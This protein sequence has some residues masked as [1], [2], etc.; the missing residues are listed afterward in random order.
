LRFLTER[1][2]KLFTDELGQSV[3]V[4]RPHGMFF[5]HRQI[6]G[7]ERG[8][9]IVEPVNR[10]AGAADGFL[11]SDCLRRR[12][13]V[14]GHRQVRIETR[15]VARNVRKLPALRRRVE[16]ALGVRKPLARQM[17]HRVGIFEVLEQRV[18][19]V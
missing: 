17:N 16:S 6:V 5:I 7:N 3:G 15:G 9:R 10:Q 13:D 11:H 12:Q 14:I 8:R 18:N 2:A 1:I 19:L 4:L